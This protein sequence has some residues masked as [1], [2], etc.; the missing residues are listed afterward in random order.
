MVSLAGCRYNDTTRR[1]GRGCRKSTLIFSLPG[2]IREAPRTPR[3]PIPWSSRA[4]QA[5][6][7]RNGASMRRH[8]T[9]R[10]GIVCSASR[11][12]EATSPS[13]LKP[14]LL[15]PQ[16]TGATAS[17]NSAADHHA[18]AA[19]SLSPSPLL[20]ACRSLRGAY[21]CDDAPYTSTPS[22]TTMEANKITSW[23]AAVTASH[24]RC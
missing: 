7:R 14:P 16:A 2:R 18:S 11:M 6:R 5:S 19:K 9:V 8:A 23:Q 3:T 24:L 20:H 22:H 13:A 15:Q 17:H 1:N 10:H 4:R 21:A 12:I